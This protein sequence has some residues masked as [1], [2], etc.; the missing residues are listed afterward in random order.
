M[1]RLF[2]ILL[3]LCRTFESIPS[4]AIMHALTTDVVK[5]VI[6]ISIIKNMLLI[7]FILGFEAFN[8]ESKVVNPIR[9][10]PN[11]CTRYC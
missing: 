2:K 11:V 10:K 4:S 3:F 8:F 1:Q 9:I 5:P 7:A 6:N